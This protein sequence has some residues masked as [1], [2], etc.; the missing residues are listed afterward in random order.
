LKISYYQKQYL[1]GG[2]CQLFVNKGI[3]EDIEVIDFVPQYP[4]VM[5]QCSY[6][7]GDYNYTKSY[8]KNKIGVYRYDIDQSLLNI[9]LIPCKFFIYIDYNELFEEKRQ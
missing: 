1:Y 9:K 2:R 6:P 7:I 3:Y 4:A 8:V 5:D